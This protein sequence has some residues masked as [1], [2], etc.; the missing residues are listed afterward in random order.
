MT[1]RATLAGALIAFGAMA[2]LASLPGWAQPAIYACPAKYEPQKVLPAGWWSG[3]R[4][5]PQ[6]LH[7][8]KG[9]GR[10]DGIWIVSGKRGEEL[11]EA[12]AILVP[13]RADGGW[14]L[15]G[16]KDG[17]LLVCLY[18]GLETYLATEVPAG[19]KGCVSE[20]RFGGDGL[21]SNGK[22]TCR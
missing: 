3:Q 17:V 11:A 14:D 7:Q 15:T 5:E 4:H 8:T 19:V 20:A 21:A 16:E 10:L 1:R 13:D 9:K 6:R 18:R 12:P 22:V 2:S